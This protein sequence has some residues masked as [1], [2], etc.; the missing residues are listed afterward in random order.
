MHSAQTEEMRGGL[1]QRSFELA[2]LERQLQ[3]IRAGAGRVIVVQ[4]PAGV[5]KSSLV[6]AC[7]RSASGAPAR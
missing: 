5:G 7:A 3:Q 6:R 4:G 1:L 2:A